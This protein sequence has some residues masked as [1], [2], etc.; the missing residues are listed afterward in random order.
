MLS[1]GAGGPDAAIPVVQDRWFL[2]SVHVTTENQIISQRRRHV[3]LQFYDVLTTERQNEQHFGSK[4]GENYSTNR[5]NGSRAAHRAELNMRLD[6]LYYLFDP[7]ST[8]ILTLQFSF[9]WATGCGKPRAWPSRLC[10]AKPPVLFPERD[11]RRC[12]RAVDMFF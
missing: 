12:V 1:A 2:I 7:I 9:R 11:E 4:S 6:R 8:I 5:V 10:D 3:F